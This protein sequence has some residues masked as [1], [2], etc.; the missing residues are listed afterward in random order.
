MPQLFTLSPLRKG[1]RAAGIETR[2][3]NW[4]L[5][6]LQHIQLGWHKA[7]AWF[8]GWCCLYRTALPEESR[9]NQQNH[10]QS[11]SPTIWARGGLRSPPS[12]ENC[13]PTASLCGTLSS[14]KSHKKVDCGVTSLSTFVQHGRS[15]RC[16]LRSVH[17]GLHCIFSFLPRVRSKRQLKIDWFLCF[18]TSVW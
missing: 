11:A 5:L 6:T 15:G 2:S 17:A 9:S 12:E 8:F 7:F 18:C 13:W 1:A 16:V 14:M 3:V 4:F 10:L